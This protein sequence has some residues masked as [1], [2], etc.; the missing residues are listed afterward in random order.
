MTLFLE[1]LSYMK[2]VFLVPYLRGGVLNVLTHNL[3]GL[4]LLAIKS[5]A[6]QSIDIGLSK[7]S[8]E[9]F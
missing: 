9:S 5:S 2:T 1:M 6:I 4:F 8:N 3:L 7:K